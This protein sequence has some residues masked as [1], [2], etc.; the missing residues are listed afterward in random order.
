MASPPFRA[1]APSAAARSSR[2]AAD[3]PPH[4]HDEPPPAQPEGAR[5]RPD[6][7]RMTRA[8]RAA[9][10]RAV[11]GRLLGFGGYI[12]LE[13]DPRFVLSAPPAPR[14]DLGTGSSARHHPST[15]LP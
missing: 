10:R 11:R 8:A 14:P 7:G 6:Q 2:S 13:S 12:V 5:W 9:R 4:E 1:R 3:H 15:G